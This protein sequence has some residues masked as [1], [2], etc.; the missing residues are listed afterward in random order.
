MAPHNSWKEWSKHV[1]LELKRLNERYEALDSKVTTIMT[2]IAA[3]KVKA[4]I[5][6]LM[7]GLIPAIGVLI[8]WLVGRK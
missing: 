6:G 7:G 2:E 5:W 8:W 1:I 4:G 3:L